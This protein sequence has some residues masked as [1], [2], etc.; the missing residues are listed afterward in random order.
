MTFFTTICRYN[1][2]NHY[3]LDVTKGF[4]TI[5]FICILMDKKLVQFKFQYLWLCLSTSYKQLSFKGFTKFLIFTFVDLQYYLLC[6]EALIFINC[7][8]CAISLWWDATKHCNS[9]CQMFEGLRYQVCPKGSE[10]TRKSGNTDILDI[11]KTFICLVLNQDY[12]CRSI[13]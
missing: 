5:K 9:T 1:W 6:R 7:V 2:L 10:S 4:F 8:N 3:R 13:N 11:K 12:F